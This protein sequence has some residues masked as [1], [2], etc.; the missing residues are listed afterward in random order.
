M[1]TGNPDQPAIS[2]SAAPDLDSSS[3]DEDFIPDANPS[4]LPADELS[5]DSE[6]E[7]SDNEAATKGPRS[8][9]RKQARGDNLE[10][11][12]ASGDEATIRKGKRKKQKKGKAAA[13]AGDSG[14]ESGDEDGEG[15]LIKTRSQ[16]AKEYAPA[17]IHPALSSTPM[18][19]SPKPVSNLSLLRRQ[20]EK[21]PLASTANATVDVD[22]LWASMNTNPSS[23]PITTCPTTSNQGP[24]TANGTPVKGT[25]TAI[26]NKQSRG[27]PPSADAALD[28][29]ITIH[30]TYTF[31]GQTTTESQ[32]VPKSSASALL[33]LQSQNPQ[34]GSLSSPSPTSTSTPPLRRPK[35]RT[36]L[37]DPGTTSSSTSTRDLAAAK[38]PKLN[39]IEKSKLDWAGYVDKEGLKED[40]DVHSRAKEGY[41][42]RMDFLGRVEAKRE[43]EGRRAK[44]L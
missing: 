43:E 17:T 37:F 40:L 14:E 32:T 2:L 5:P 23:K 4:A 16:R 41:L 19:L 6:S 9:K 22:A 39:T 8:K 15:V 27:E 44:G 30:R 34:S 13:A 12:F 18:A 29:T 11:E 28:E 36:S 38:A 20:K 3:D 26:A 42:G 1:A 31:A 25:G 24:S 35:K 7:F 33:Y 21:K 10:L